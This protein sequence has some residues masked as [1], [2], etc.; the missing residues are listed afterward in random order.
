M[1]RAL[2]NFGVEDLVQ[3]GSMA[4]QSPVRFGEGSMV[5]GSITTP[6]RAAVAIPL[7]V[8]QVTLN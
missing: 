5:R 8:D 6:A 2:V 7:L 1:T 4:I 3:G